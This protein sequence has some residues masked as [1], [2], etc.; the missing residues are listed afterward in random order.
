MKEEIIVFNKTNTLRPQSII[1]KLWRLIKPLS[2]KF[3]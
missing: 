3:R 1:I 2:R